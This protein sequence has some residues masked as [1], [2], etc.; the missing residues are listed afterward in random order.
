MVP[1]F[2]CVNYVVLSVMKWKNM[3]YTRHHGTEL[4]WT[5][6]CLYA[7]WMFVKYHGS[8][9][10]YLQ[11]LLYFAEFLCTR[12]CKTM[13]DNARWCKRMQDDARWC[14]TMQDDARQCKTM[15]DDARWCKMVQVNARRC[16]VMQ[17]DARWCKMMQDKAIWLKVV[18]DD[19][20][21]CVISKIKR[22]DVCYTHH[23]GTELFFVPFAWNFQ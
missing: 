5:S 1:S 4:L 9:N 20:R 14:K 13:Q 19:A 18:Q 6:K 21:W 3:C 12:W 23:H 8:A 16:K 22:S 11:D 2:F 15:Q 17:G 10:Q 7:H